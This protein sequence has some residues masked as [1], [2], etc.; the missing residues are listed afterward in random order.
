MCRAPREQI[1]GIYAG[2]FQKKIFGTLRV[3]GKS[4]QWWPFFEF[5]Q[6]NFD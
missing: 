4:V 3:G 6:E 5:K 2:L 1:A